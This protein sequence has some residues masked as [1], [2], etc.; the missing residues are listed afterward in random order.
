MLDQA[1]P[2]RGDTLQL[3]L[4]LDDPAPP[5]KQTKVEQKSLFDFSD[6]GAA[7]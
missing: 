4:M 7:N 3:P 5:T 2:K 1:L 6:E